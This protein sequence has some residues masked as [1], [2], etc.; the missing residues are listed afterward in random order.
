MAYGTISNQT[1]SFDPSELT[2]DANQI[3]GTLAASQIPGLDASKIISGVFSS[4]L[5]PNLS[6]SKIT[7]GTLPVAR[8]GTGAS[9]LDGL[10]S[11]L[12]Q[13]QYKLFTSFTVSVTFTPILVICLA[14]NRS[15]PRAG[16]LG[17][18]IRDNL[19]SSSGNQVIVNYEFTVK[20]SYTFANPVLTLEVQS[21]SVIWDWMNGIVIGV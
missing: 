16:V 12:G 13:L 17:V 20:E 2:I 18:A 19:S 3:S 6:A 7:S 15:N 1:F 5:I 10:K 4:G 21:G 14:A 11:S 9:S 8:G